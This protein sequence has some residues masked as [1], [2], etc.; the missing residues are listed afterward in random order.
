MAILFDEGN[1][2]FY[3]QTNNTSYVMHLLQSK[4]LQHVFW[5]KKIPSI[6]ACQYQKYYECEQEFSKNGGT[7][8]SLPHE[9]PDFGNGDF[10]KPAL[11]VNCA[12]GSEVIELE[13]SGY[14]IYDGKKPLKGLPATYARDAGDQTLEITLSDEKTGLSIVLRY[15]AFEKHD[16]IARSVT[17]LNGGDSEIKLKTAMSA[18]LDMELE[19]GFRLLSLSGAWANENNVIEREIKPGSFS[20]ESRRIA[21]SH[22]NNPFIALLSGNAG[23]DCGDVYGFSLVY[24]GSFLCDIETDI[25]FNA[26]VRVGLNPFDFEW[27]LSPGESFTTPEVVM[28]YSDEGL[29][30]MSR[31]YHRLYRECLCRGNFRDKERPILINNWEATYFDFDEKKLLE[32]ADEAAKL[33]VE[34]FVLDDGWFGSRDDDTSSLGDWHT[35]MKKLPH[36]LKYL[37]E[38]INQ[39]GMKFGLWVEPEMISPDSDL[40]RAHPDWCIHV[41]GRDRLTIRNQFVLD[42]TRI[43]VRDWIVD[44]ISNV[45]KEA[46]V[47]YVKWDMNRNITSPGSPSLDAKRQKEFSHRYILGLY[48]ILERITSAFPNVLFEGCAS[49]GGRFDPG[50]LYYMPQTW[51][52]DDTDAVQRVKIQYGTSIVYPAITMG[53]HVSAVPNHIMGRVTPL[54]TRQNTAMCGN[55][56]FELDVTKLDDCEKE[57][58]A[59]SIKYY[60]EIRR[61]VQFGDL[62]RLESLY[63]GNCAALMYV[64]ED[65]RDAVVFLFRERMELR[66][67][68][69]TLRLKGLDLTADYEICELGIRM[70]AVELENVGLVMPLGKGDFQ[71]CIMRLHR[72]N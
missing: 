22:Q 68:A 19:K 11:V 20:V 21:S 9:Y 24:S 48:D 72:V 37:S 35:D 36:G 6:S 31:I 53:A 41:D 49:G 67:A 54:E 71:S 3:I 45:L 32:I 65:R 5:G 27:C 10:R 16:A 64:A 38:K 51:T 56:G 55:Y 12:D 63:K 14:K 69:R 7:M 15:T 29:G 59:E 2:N 47:S 28:V 17:V 1:K 8:D 23:E 50:M 30:K 62:Y 46:G 40:Y 58:I 4:Y 57:K 44:T 13:Y 42:L 34:L 26:R 33:G 39:K 61:I 66:K 25:N 43:E 70:P 18:S 52:S 60:K